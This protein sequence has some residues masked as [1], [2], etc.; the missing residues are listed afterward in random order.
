[1]KSFSVLMALCLSVAA[2]TCFS[3]PAC[4]Q[5]EKEKAESS[6]SPKIL[7]DL[8]YVENGH[9]RQKL[10]LYLPD[11][12]KGPLLIWIHG[13]GWVGGSKDN[14]PG[15][16]MLK[17]GVAVASVEYRF[18]QDAPFPAQIEDCKAAVRW[19]RAHADD[20]GYSK[21]RFAAWGASAGGHLVAMLGVTGQIK[22]F[23]VGANLDQSSAVQAVI[24]WFG[25]ADIVGYTENQPVPMVAPDNPDSLLAKLLGGPISGKMELAKRASPVSWVTK[26][27]APT[28]IMQGT[29]DPLVPLS[30]SERLYEK[31]KAVGVDVT[32]DVIDGAGHGGPEFTTAEKI[33]LMTRFLSKHWTS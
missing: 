24:D 25:P 21:D 23:D 13:G 2:L 11:H 15:L 1:M 28:L 10:D 27:A 8:A 29:K 22:D 9:A 19:L 26:D 20:Y 16:Q 33:Q 5:E 3:N 14:P 7:R 17:M 6:K 31:L 4:A 18:S 30:Q 32:L 12:P